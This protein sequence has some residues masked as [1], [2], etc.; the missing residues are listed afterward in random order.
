MATKKQR[1]SAWQYTIKRK[2]VL[3][4]PIYLTFDT[5][6]EGD[7]YVAALEAQID[8]GIVPDEYLE[9]KAI[10]TIK[11]LAREYLS[12]VSVSGTDS[13]MLGVVIDRHGKTRIDAITYDWC[14]TWV[15][16]MKLQLHLAPSTIR[17]H[18]GALARCLDWAARKG[19][20][21]RGNPLRLL[22]KN[23]AQYTPADLK[24]V[25]P[26]RRPGDGARDRRLAPGEHEKI[27]RI[28]IENPKPEG[29]Q[30]PLDLPH[31]TALLCMYWLAVATGMRLSEIFTLERAQVD[32][33]ERTI[34]LDRTKNGD[35]RQVPLFPHA[36]DALLA[37]MPHAGEVFMFP[38]WAGGDDAERKRVGDM[39]SKQF[40]RI[41]EAAKCDGLTFHDLR[42]EATCWY[43]EA[44]NFTDVE[45]A[46]SL[47]WKST[48]MALRYA[49]LR[50]SK[51]ADASRL[52]R[53]SSGH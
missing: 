49:N 10:P 41:F 18:V 12:K 37:Y 39:L 36:V 32:L 34:Y 42:H 27:L 9:Q 22:P 38:Q 17:H 48:K 4:K 21:V 13:R 29:R 25:P 16:Q 53:A 33:V 14:E 6:V 2:G 31:R 23:Y 15:V 24:A 45:V 44:T 35:K 8:A 46:K 11:D 1:G 7:A 51:L 30:R 19:T 50:A 20:M 28:L 5:E 40:S 47:G 3:P 52:V 26:S 43:Y